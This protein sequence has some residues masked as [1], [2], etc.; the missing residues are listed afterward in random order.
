MAIASKQRQK[1]KNISDK[2]NAVVPQTETLYAVDPN[3]QPFF[4]YMRAPVNYVSS[5][6]E[7]PYDTHYFLVRPGNEE[8]AAVSEQ[9]APRHPR[10]ILKATDYRKQTVIVFVIDP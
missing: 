9:W 2:I 1:V 5:L 3:Y 10:S 8:A 6:E 4:F 7:L